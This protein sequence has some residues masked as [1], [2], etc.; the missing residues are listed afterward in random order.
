VFLSVITTILLSRIAESQFLVRVTV[1]DV[2]GAIAVGFLAN[3]AGY[4]V[5][6]PY[7]RTKKDGKDGTD[8]DGGNRPAVPEMTDR[9]IEESLRAADAQ[10]TQRT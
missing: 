2:W 4:N 6:A 9:E 3:F 1:N 7:V 10:A 8:T 5:L